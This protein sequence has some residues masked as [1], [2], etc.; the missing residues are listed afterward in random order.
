M[1]AFKKTKV[2]GKK[3]LKKGYKYAKGGKVVKVKTKKRG[4]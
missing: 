3:V 1:S 4:K 2:K